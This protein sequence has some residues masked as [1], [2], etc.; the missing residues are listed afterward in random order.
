MPVIERQAG[1]F[2]Y[3][4][5]TPTTRDIVQRR[6]GEIQDLMRRSAADIVDI[7]L[8]LTEVKGILGHGNFGIWLESEFGWSYPTAA[9][10]MKVAD[11]FKSL[12]FRDLEIAPSA[13]YSLASGTTPAPIR[14]EF[15]QRAEA[16]EKIT[17]SVVKARLD[18]H[19]EQFQPVTPVKRPAPVAPTFPPFDAETGEILPS[20]DHHEV[21]A[22]IKPDPNHV[23][24]KNEYEQQLEQ[25]GYADASKLENVAARAIAALT[26]LTTYPVSELARIADSSA[27]HGFQLAAR[28]S[29]VHQ[30]CTALINLSEVNA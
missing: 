25:I 18:T 30:L 20:A 16:G 8:K 19:R 2:D 14:E 22:L 24:Q 9:N 10:F 11:S 15:I 1:L 23:I 7:G 4:A 26:A 3:D 13:L 29:R 17:H 5:L 6:T 27:G 21:Q 28:L 12:N